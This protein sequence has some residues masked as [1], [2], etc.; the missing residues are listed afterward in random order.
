MKDS[1]LFVFKNIISKDISWI[2]WRW[3]GKRIAPSTLLF[4]GPHKTNGFPATVRLFSQ[5]H[6][7]TIFG[8][9]LF[10]KRFEI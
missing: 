4:H 2:M 1:C 6:P 10:G 7:T 5:G 8:K 9:Y 3:F